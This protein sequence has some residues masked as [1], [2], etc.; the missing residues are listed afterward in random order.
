ML[1][2]YTVRF[3][4]SARNDLASMKRYIL[5]KFKYPQYGLSFDNKI[6]RATASIKNSPIS[7]RT[8][9][10]TYRGFDIYMRCIHAYLF[11]YIVD[12]D[13]IS[14]IRVLRDGMNWEYIIK[15]W[16]RNNGDM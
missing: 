6:K 10:F 5:N 7:F 15:L 14:I 3:V 9:G 16:L 2:N 13:M 4:P 1:K 12:D 11:F 8:T